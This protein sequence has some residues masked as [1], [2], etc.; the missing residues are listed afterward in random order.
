VLEQKEII[1]K[2]FK[3]HPRPGRFIVDIVNYPDRLALRLY[4]DDFEMLPDSRRQEAVEWLETTLR[5]LN[6]ENKFVV[7]FE[8]EGKPNDL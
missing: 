3:A 8:M 6:H 5:D 2:Y 1:K 4:R 7:T